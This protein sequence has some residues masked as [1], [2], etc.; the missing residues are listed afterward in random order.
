MVLY[1]P[2]RRDFLKLS[3]WAAAALPVLGPA[4]RRVLAAPA[5]AAA[6]GYDP[7]AMFDIDVT[8]VE[9]AATRPAAC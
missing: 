5:A 6:P 4:A 2:G 3:A 7:G 8:E 1:P 9:Y